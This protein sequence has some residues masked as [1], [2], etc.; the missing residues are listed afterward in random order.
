VG[1]GFEPAFFEKTFFDTKALT[2]QAGADSFK[3]HGIIDRIDR[4]ADGNLLIIDYKTS[5]PSV[6]TAKSLSEGK[7]L[8]LPLYALAA[9]DA[10][11]LGRPVDGFYWH[12][13]HGE[14]SGL[15]LGDFGLEAALQM[16]VDKAWEAVRAVRGGRF[17][18]QPPQEGCPVYCPAAAFC[19]RYRPGY[20]G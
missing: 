12:I 18:P 15:S 13:R 1:L 10:L 19:W 2:V 5:G 7:K 20:R 4:D 16:A 6:Y 9:R 8:Q 11:E 14:P 17:A 3:L